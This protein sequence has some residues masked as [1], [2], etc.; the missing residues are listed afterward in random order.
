MGRARK[1]SQIHSKRTNLSLQRSEMIYR[2]KM[3]LRP[4]ATGRSG[5]ERHVTSNAQD[6]KAKA[7]TVVRDLFGQ[8][9]AE[10]VQA[11]QERRLLARV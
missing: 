8:S 4:A 7:G 6:E 1:T 2:R 9:L 3:R 11:T 5:A 10:T